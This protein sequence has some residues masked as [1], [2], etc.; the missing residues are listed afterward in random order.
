M[1]HDHRDMLKDLRK[2]GRKK[3]MIGMTG[4]DE[5]TDPELKAIV[6]KALPKVT[7]HRKG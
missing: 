1:E 6:A 4:N 3:N 5:D 2:A 7:N